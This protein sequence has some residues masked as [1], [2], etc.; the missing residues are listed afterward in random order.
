M[1]R[2]S[3]LYDWKTKPMVRL[4]SLARPSSSSSATGVPGQQVL[5]VGRPVEAAQ[6]VHHRGLA[7]AGRPDD[8]HELAGMDLEADV[9]EGRDLHPAHRVDPADLVERD[10]RSSSIVSRPAAEAA[11]P[12]T[13]GEP[14]AAAQAAA[15]RRRRAGP[16]RVD[17]G[18]HGLALGQAAGDL[19]ERAGD[20]ADLDRLWPSGRRRRRGPGP[21]SRRRC[22]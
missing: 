16:G 12:A 5:A 21:C 14:Q 6:D 15:G 11:A 18:D 13:D 7:R 20:Q 19:G 22:R 8:R 3:R 4:R 1:V 2:G 9:D 17:A 10:D